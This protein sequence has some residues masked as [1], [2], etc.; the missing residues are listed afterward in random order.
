MMLQQRL[1]NYKENRNCTLL[2]VG[3]MS[4]N[5]IDASIEL[6]EQYKAPKERISISYQQLNKSHYVFKLIV[7]ESKQKAVTLLKQGVNLPITRAN[8]DHE[9]IYH[10]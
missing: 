5:C 7:G 4:K 3:P 8:G 1:K 10:L 2:G 6:A 9:K